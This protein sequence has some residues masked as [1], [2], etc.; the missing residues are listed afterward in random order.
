M[1]LGAGIGIQVSLKMLAGIGLP[2]SRRGSIVTE[3]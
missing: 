2:D 1:E 3:L